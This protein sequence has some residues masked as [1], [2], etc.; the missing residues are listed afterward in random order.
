MH[1]ILA[2]Y[3]NCARSRSFIL[4]LSHCSA[5]FLEVANTSKREIRFIQEFSIAGPI[6]DEMESDVARL[7]EGLDDC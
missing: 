4:R 2:R 3:A 6:S 5:E 1:A 7:V